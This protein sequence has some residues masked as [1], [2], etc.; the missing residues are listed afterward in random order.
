ML[1]FLR[2]PIGRWVALG[3]MLPLLAAL[4]GWIGRVA[5]RR[6]GHPTRT[7]RAMLKMSRIANRGKASPND[8][9]VALPAARS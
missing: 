5:Q 3:V 4:F 7:S 1:L 8:A 9:D 6:S 2:S